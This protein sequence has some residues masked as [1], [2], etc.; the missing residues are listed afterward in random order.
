MYRVQH[1]TYS[2]HLRRNIARRAPSSKTPIEEAISTNSQVSS[3]EDQVSTSK[4]I[5]F[6][7]NEM[8]FFTLKICVI[9]QLKTIKNINKYCWKVIT[10]FCRSNHDKPVNDFCLP[11]LDSSTKS[12]LSGNLFNGT[13]ASHNWPAE[14][15]V[16]LRSKSG[17]E[18]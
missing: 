6:H 2:L 15:G 13:Q 17:R 9:Q 3:K 11:F 8:Q 12:S 16:V 5:K 1:H 4:N 10:V 18:C 14:Q 7:R